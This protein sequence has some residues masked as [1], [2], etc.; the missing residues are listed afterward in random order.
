LAVPPK[1]GL[2]AAFLF[3]ILGNSALGGTPR[4]LS[5]LKPLL[6]EGVWD[7]VRSKA[8][9]SK[10]LGVPPGAGSL[11]VFG[12]ASDIAYPSS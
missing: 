2:K 1:A 3:P 7:R 6:I 9:S 5:P 11:R 10:R 4:D 8:S 12:T